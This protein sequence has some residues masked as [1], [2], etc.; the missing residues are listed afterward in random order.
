MAEKVRDKNCETDALRFK[1]GEK[2]TFKFVFPKKD[3]HAENLQFL[4]VIKN[5]STET[6]SYQIATRVD[7]KEK[8]MTLQNIIIAR[9]NA[10]S[11]DKL[12]TDQRQSK[13]DFVNVSSNE[14]GKN[15]IN[16]CLLT[17]KF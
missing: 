9:E 17:Y 5:Y 6:E 1:K 13:D 15:F 11:Q 3:E 16:Y 12:S 7:D 10:K 2:L 14:T 4:V 8:W